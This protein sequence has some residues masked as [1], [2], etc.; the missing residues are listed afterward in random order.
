M[1]VER[2]YDDEALISLMETGRVASDAHLPSCKACSEK[3]QSFRDLSDVLHDGAVWDRRPLSEEP[4]RSTI[5]TLRAF[6]DRM[7]DEDTRA[8]VYLKDLLAASREE[9]MP[10]LQQHP[11]YRTAGMVRKL[12][13]AS[14]G[15]IDTMP[16]DA[17]EITRLATE[18]ADHLDPTSQ[19]SDTVA[20]LRGAAW[21]DRAYVLFYTGQFSDALVAI[22]RA[23]VAFANCVVDEY[24]RARAGIVRSLTLRAFERLADA[25]I[26]ATDSAS[27][28]LRFEDIQRTA[29]ANMAEA[30]LLFSL[31][32]FGAAAAVLERLELHLRNSHHAETHA[33]VLANLGY[34]SRRL[35][36]L[37]AALEY[38]ELSTA[39]FESLGVP[40]EAARN[41]FNAA[42]IMA[43]AGRIRD[44]FERLNKSNADFEQLGMADEAAL[45]SL[46][47]A[48]LLLASDRFDEV[49]ELSRAAMR[50]FERAGV[51]Y[52]SRALTALA[53]IREAAQKRTASAKLIRHVRDYIRRLP[54][55]PNLLFATPPSL[56]P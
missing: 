22:D 45:A 23:D 53:Y 38:Y 30:H 24:D 7:T 3:L 6:A 41:R 51:A 12:I 14:E 55:Q 21:R 50:S 39:I 20:R 32:D 46:D 35:G 37:D 16:P 27:A 5:E 11:E 2:H 52:T 54:S 48:E 40:T 42:L 25:R 9:W 33:R 43:E 34:C 29:S 18:I 17:V 8:E 10:R 28:F 26:A 56:G 15:A 36:K 4:V 1:M 47:M 13:A 31:N 49:E 44:A 19:P